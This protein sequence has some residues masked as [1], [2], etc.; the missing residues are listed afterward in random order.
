MSERYKAVEGSESAHCCFKATVVDT[1]TSNPSFCDEL[2][3]VCECFDMESAQKIAD[4]LNTA[5]YNCNLRKD[6]ERY[7]WLRRGGNDDIG[8]VR[9]FN[10]ADRGSA[11]VAYTYEEVLCGDRLDAAI[12]AAIKEENP[13]G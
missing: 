9:D 7:R 10:V 5:H 2:D 12:D 3:W 4:A 13:A 6:A 1:Q 8:V 11:S